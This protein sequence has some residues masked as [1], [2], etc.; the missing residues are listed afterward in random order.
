MSPVSTVFHTVVTVT[1]NINFIPQQRTL[2][3]PSLIL[4]EQEWERASFMIRVS[5][6]IQFITEGRLRHTRGPAHKK[7]S[8]F[9]KYPISI[10]VFQ[11]RN[12]CENV[13]KFNEMIRAYFL[14]VFSSFCLLS[15]SLP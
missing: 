9:H 8:P 10:D 2:F 12:I 15:T 3:R 11:K 7:L 6:L 14:A 13:Y 5:G 4:G 1:L